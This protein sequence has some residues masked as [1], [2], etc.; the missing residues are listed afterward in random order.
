MIYMEKYQLTPAEIEELEERGI[1]PDELPNA[2]QILYSFENWLE[3]NPLSLMRH[4]W[5]ICAH[6]LDE[7]EY[8][9]SKEKGKLTLFILPEREWLKIQRCKEN[10]LREFETA[11]FEALVEGFENKE[12][13]SL[14]PILLA[15][16]ELE[17]VVNLIGNEFPKGMTGVVY[18]NMAS[19]SPP[20]IWLRYRND[21]GDKSSVSYWYEKIC[22]NGE[23][24][25]MYVSHPHI[26][27]TAKELNSLAP[28]DLHFVVSALALH[29]FKGYLEERQAAQKRRT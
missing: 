16:N 10:K 23:D 12:K 3:G 26:A 19:F 27:Q 11:Y 25:A 1:T 28:D 18:S 22:V 24:G 17:K 14:E 21:C 5:G 4:G 6:Y 2:V 8:A 9:T 20:K 29:R 13:G 7:N 15:K